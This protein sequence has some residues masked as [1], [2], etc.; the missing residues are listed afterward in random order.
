VAGSAASGRSV[1]AFLLFRVR[2][3][4]LMVAGKTARRRLAARSA[5]F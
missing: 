5:N 3:H 2:C 1:I 4:P